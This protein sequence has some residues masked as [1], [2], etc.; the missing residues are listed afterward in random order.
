MSK[1][2][3]DAFF[4]T[5]IPILKQ[6]YRKWRAPY[7]TAVAEEE[8][9]PFHVLI[10][11]IISLRTKD[12][13]TAEASSRLFK[14]AKDPKTMALL[15]ENTISKTI[16]PAGFYKTKA[17][18]ILAICRRLNLEF[19]GVVPNDLDTLLTFNGV[20]R[21]TANLVLTRG[22][23]LPGICVDTHVHRISNRFGILKTETPEETE[24]RLRKILP[25]KYWIIYN[26]LLVAFG[27]NLC[28]PISPH[29]SECKLANHCR[30]IGVQQRR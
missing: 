14:L 15:P 12:E 8:R 2:S 24:F 3:S 30:K 9:N 16:Y 27:Q 21:K 10:S 11:T 29:C 28:R 1:K 17:K 25:Q 19:N 26:D 5:I 22:F 20:G 13:T 6:E 4:D 7:V 23:N 18:T